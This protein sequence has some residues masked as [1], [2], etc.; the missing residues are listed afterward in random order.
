MVAINNRVTDNGKSRT[1]DIQGKE[2]RKIFKKKLKKKEKTS[3]G[4][5]R[6][7]R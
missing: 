6:Q 4:N 5:V 2:D 3:K 1:I 7:K